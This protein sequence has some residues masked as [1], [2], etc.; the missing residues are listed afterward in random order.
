ML[1]ECPYPCPGWKDFLTISHIPK[2]R[3]R[4]SKTARA[5]SKLL[6]LLLKLLLEKMLIARQFAKTPSKATI[7][8]PYP[9]KIR[10]KRGKSKIV[11]LFHF[12]TC[13]LTIIIIIKF[14]E[15]ME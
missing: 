5:M 13:D 11:Y 15:Y 12:L 3:K 2:S 6:K 14:S 8:A 4:R 10:L 7:S 1:K 9:S